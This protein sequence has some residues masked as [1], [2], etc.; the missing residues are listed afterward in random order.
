[1]RLQ[2]LDPRPSVFIRGSEGRI[3]GLG[4]GGIVKICEKSQKGVDRLWV[5]A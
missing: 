5:G 4:G 3:S 2:S 1:M